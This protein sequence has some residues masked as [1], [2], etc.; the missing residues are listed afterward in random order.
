MG[1]CKF[2]EKYC[3]GPKINYFRCSK[4]NFYAKKTVS[5]VERF[6]FPTKTD[7]ALVPNYQS[8]FTTSTWPILFPT[9][10]SK[11]TSVM[12]SVGS[13]LTGERPKYSP[14]GLSYVFSFNTRTLETTSCTVFRGWLESTYKVLMNCFFK[15]D[16]RRTRG[17]GV[18]VEPYVCETPICEM[19]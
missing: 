8:S 1:V 9:C 6:K 10:I 5:N 16:K 15:I 3:E 2:I 17:V 12:L 4:N 11:S 18:T 13:V 14:E 19:T 7:E